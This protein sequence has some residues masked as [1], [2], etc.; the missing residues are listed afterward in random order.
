MIIDL[1]KTSQSI[2][3][4][5]IFYLSKLVSLK[6]WNQP[7]IN[8]SEKQKL[9]WLVRLR[10]LFILLGL[11]LFFPALSSGYLASSKAPAFIGLI[12]ILIVFNLLV[13][14][15][16]EKRVN[17]LHPLIIAFHMAFDLLI[18]TGLLLLT[19]GF[20][21][22]FILILLLHCSIA[23]I[24]LNGPSS[25]NF[26]LLAHTLLL[27]LQLHSLYQL[28][29]SQESLLPTF[30]VYHFVLLIFWLVMRSFG[31][32]L[33]RAQELESTF[34]KVVAQQNRL[35][36]IGALTA[37]FCHEFAS[38]LNT[39]SIRLDRLS[40]KIMTESD[41][42]TNEIFEM[43]AAIEACQNTLNQLNFAQVDTKSTESKNINLNELLKS[44]VSNWQ[45]N[46]E[47]QVKISFNQEVKTFA[48][49]INII[50]VITNL[51][52][53][54]FEANPT[55]VICLELD[56]IEKWIILRTRD[57]G[58]GFSEEQLKRI[59]E[60]FF[61]TKKMGTGL[62][63]YVSELIIQSIG[64]NLRVENNRE[65]GAC[66]SLSWPMIEGSFE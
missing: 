10:W 44:T 37:G 5:L 56:V 15:F 9:F 3:D 23:A 17:Q 2:V 21:N 58:P 29:L 61:S 30:L 16:F 60:P 41:E 14:L 42:V 36:S 13:S 49:S 48:P 4:F 38:P 12:S 45:Q 46:K 18:V 66:I 32:V 54:A 8:T 26:L 11:V 53:N 6:D 63:L 19:G 28:P 40:R 43:K 55:G 50:Q 51:L 31:R 25:W 24:L 65:G 47:A 1:K 39:A 35:K 20:A 57:Q 62:G 33:K 34:L 64:G 27:T 22:P 52:D 59:G 7:R